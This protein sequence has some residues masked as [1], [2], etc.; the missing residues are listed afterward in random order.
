MGLV[1]LLMFL[2]IPQFTN[3]HGILCHKL[4]FEGE[5]AALKK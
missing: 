2:A 5:N 1:R 4:G 3:T